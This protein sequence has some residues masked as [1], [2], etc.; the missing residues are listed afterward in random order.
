[1][2]F[3]KF[4]KRFK[5]DAPTNDKDFKTKV[6]R[7]VREWMFRNNLSSENAFDAL[8]RT[9]GKHLNKNLNRAL[10]QRAMAA[11]EVGLSFAKVDSLF[12][13]LANEANGEIDLGMWLA[14]IYED[15]DN[16]IQMIRE[17]VVRHQLTQD[18]LLHQ[19]KLKAW[20]NG[21]TLP[22]LREHIRNL[23]SSVSDSQITS[24]YKNLKDASGVVQV[25][26]LISNFTGSPFETI[27]FRNKIFKQ[28]YTEIY[29]N[30]EERVIQ[31]L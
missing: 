24:L 14:K 20:N 30:N 15:D 2:T 12:V 22:K 18:D 29:P 3:E 13:E 10:F 1:M 17:I 4:E 27:D 31:L 8:C 6:I 21:L 25:S 26:N 11:M 19:M 23:D 7:H 28:L 9:V 16:P 5:S